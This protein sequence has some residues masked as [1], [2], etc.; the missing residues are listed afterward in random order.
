M[1][2]LPVMLQLA[3]L[4]FGVALTV[5]L[6][7]LDV[8]AAGVVLVVTSFG[9][10]FYACITVIATK[11]SDCPFQTPLSVLLPKVLPWAKE[12]TALARVW[13]RR[14]AIRAAATFQSPPLKANFLKSTTEH[15]FRIFTG[16]ANTQSH[17]G[18]DTLN[19]DYPMTLSN[20]ALWR[21]DPLFDSPVPEDIGASAGFWLLENSTDF[22]AASAVAAVFSDLQWPS[23]HRSTTALVR[24][25]DTYVECFR[26]PE[27]KKSTSLKA[28]QSATAYYVLYHAQLIWS[29]S[30]SLEAEA[31]K[32][33]P[34][35]PPDLF[36][37]LPSDEWKGDDVFEYLL[38]MNINDRSE[39]GTSARF[40]SYIA[41]FWF[42]GDS[43][44]AIR[45][46]PTR[47]Q[48][49]Y[50]LIKTL[51]ESRALNPVTLTDCVLCAGATMDFPLHPD[52]LIRV[53]K[54]YIPFLYTYA[55][56]DTD[57]AQ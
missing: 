54:R 2:L 35:L 8:S 29:A 31:G 34:D 18:E 55:N 19:D 7:D 46:R 57:R 23:H 49:L 53:D 5:Y 1:E 41:P 30:N 44:F 36:L 20:P 47:L 13:L 26:A 52:D 40:L 11:H 28:L 10:I 27:F 25:R 45:T 6:W 15:V 17:T 56:R 39:P 3:L 33:P 51:E 32:I 16:T 42:C 4:L 14:R 12:F 38:H 37:H 24:L 21:N 50:E 22:S 48:T 9:L 43:D